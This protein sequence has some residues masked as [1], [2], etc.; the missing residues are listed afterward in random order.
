[1]R[2]HNEPFTGTHAIANFIECNSDMGNLNAAKAKQLI[3]NICSQHSLQVLGGYYHDFDKQGAFT[4]VC[5]LTES[6]ISIHTWPE[7]RYVTVDVFLCNY[8]QDNSSK[9]PQLLEALQGIFKP[10]KVN[11]KLVRR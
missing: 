6:H 11:S 2:L 4:G 9:V 1:M 7:L 3:E 5:V 8:A 10:N